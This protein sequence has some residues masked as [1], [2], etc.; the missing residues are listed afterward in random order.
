MIETKE[1]LDFKS[2]AYRVSFLFE[3]GIL[4]SAKYLRIKINTLGKYFIRMTHVDIG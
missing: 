4:W 2:A 3:F 1:N